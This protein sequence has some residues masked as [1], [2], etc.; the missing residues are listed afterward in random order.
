MVL[1][2][3]RRLQQASS[4]DDQGKDKDAS[5][6]DDSVEVSTAFHCNSIQLLGL[7]WFWEKA[8]PQHVAVESPQNYQCGLYTVNSTDQQ[9]L[10]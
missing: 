7:L 6:R 3:A 10:H 1:C 5:F 9:K 8:G 2:F 4:V